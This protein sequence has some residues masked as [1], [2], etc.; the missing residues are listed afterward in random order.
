MLINSRKSILG[1]GFIKN[2]ST[3]NDIF[4]TKL[5]DVKLMDTTELNFTANKINFTSTY[6][7]EFRF[8]ILDGNLKY[9]NN[10]N[11]KKYFEISNVKNIKLKGEKLITKNRRKVNLYI[12]KIILINNHKLKL[13]FEE[14]DSLIYFVKF[15]F[16]LCSSLN[17]IVD[18][19][20]K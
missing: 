18:K 16:M 13:G 11:R 7:S 2:K 20:Y 6:E 17:I 19:N 14:Y 12:C 8:N 9:K 4:M 10:Q 5:S 3:E 15:I 1:L